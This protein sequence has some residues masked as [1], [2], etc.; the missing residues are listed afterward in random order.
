[1]RPQG[2]GTGSA[3]MNFSCAPQQHPEHAWTSSE[4]SHC[5]VL[6]SKAQWDGVG[7]GQ[8]LMEMPSHTSA[9]CGEKEPLVGYTGSSGGPTEEERHLGG[10]G[11][12]GR[13]QKKTSWSLKTSLPKGVP[14]KK[15]YRH[16]THP[17]TAW[18]A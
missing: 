6:L 3:R 15:D 5:F 14:G 12:E 16:L 7:P 4:C 13:G 8:P 10:T 17:P 1:M 18:K 11:K 9:F 2:R